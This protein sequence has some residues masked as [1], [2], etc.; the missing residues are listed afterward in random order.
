M[1][2]YI[3]GYTGGNG[4]FP[5]GN[6]RYTPSPNNHCIV[7]FIVAILL[8]NIYIALWSRFLAVQTLF[9]KGEHGIE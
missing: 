7:A 2:I 8:K 6:L 9:R 5:W 3:R 1:F 4:V